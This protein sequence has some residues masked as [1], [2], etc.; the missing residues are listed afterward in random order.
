MLLR[1]IWWVPIFSRTYPSTWMFLVL[2]EV[3]Q[4]RTG[5]QLRV[6]AAANSDLRLITACWFDCSTGNQHRE[7]KKNQKSKSNQNRQVQ[8]NDNNMTRVP[9]RVNYWLLLAAVVLLL[10]TL[11]TITNAQTVIENV[12][13]GIRSKVSFFFLQQKIFRSTFLKW[14]QTCSRWL[15]HTHTYDHH[16][17][18]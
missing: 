7:Q 16:V 6:G 11:S 17:L 9:S 18:F 12:G 2:N 3:D 13:K 5:F 14:R 10:I 8:K 4:R 15:A 1:S